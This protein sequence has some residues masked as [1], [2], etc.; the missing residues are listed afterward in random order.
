M[1][2]SEEPKLAM[3]KRIKAWLHRLLGR[4]R[5]LF[6]V[7]QLFF[8]A[9]RAGLLRDNPEYTC[10]YYVRQLVE[11]G[12]YVIDIGANLGYYTVLFAEWTG[13]EGRVYSVEPIPLFRR[14]LSRNAQSFSQVEVIPYALGDE[15]DR[16]EMGIPETADPHRHGHTQILRKD[17]QAGSREIV[18]VQVRTPSALF[19]ELSRLDY[20]KCDV[21]GHE[22]TVLPAMKELLREHRPI[23]QVEVAHDNRRPLFEMMGDLG[24]R[25]YYVQ[26]DELVSIQSP[27]DSTHGDWIF[28]PDSS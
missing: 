17:E 22:G 2:P 9:Y 15:P 28:R 5:Y 1:G 6:L 11:P 25:A 12:D 24:Y 7:S 21:E 18:E 10:H 26:D 8:L 27:T 19:E 20:V 16:V 4:R 14:I 3:V 13:P 23:V